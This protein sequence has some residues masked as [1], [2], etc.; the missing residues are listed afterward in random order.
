M[1]G[2]HNFGQTKGKPVEVTSGQRTAQ[3]NA[4]DIRITGYTKT[5]VADAAHASGSFNRVHEYPDNRGVHVDL[6]PEG[7][8]GRFG[9]W[10]PRREK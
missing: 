6:K 2:L 3:Q 7:N 8:Q 10:R 4:A 1:T 9:N 5:Q